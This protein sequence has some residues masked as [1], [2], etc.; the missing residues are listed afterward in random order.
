MVPPPH[1]TF[2]LVQLIFV[3]NITFLLFEIAAKLPSKR[4]SQLRFFVKGVG[5]EGGVPL[6]SICRDGMVL[7]I[8][9]IGYLSKVN[10][11]SRKIANIRNCV[12]PLSHLY[13]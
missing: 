7:L 6:V 5:R 10:S 13:N 11:G 4:Y 3:A 8:D 12:F 9:C 2:T 1:S